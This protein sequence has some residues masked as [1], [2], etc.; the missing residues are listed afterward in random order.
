MG[1]RQNGIFA[2]F[3]TCKVLTV[4]WDFYEIL[5]IGAVNEWKVSKQSYIEEQSKTKMGF[6]TR[7]HQK[8]CWFGPKWDPILSGEFCTSTRIPILLKG[9]KAD[10]AP[11]KVHSNA[12]FGPCCSPSRAPGRVSIF[13]A[14]PSTSLEQ[15]SGQPFGLGSLPRLS[16]TFD[17]ST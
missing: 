14:E 8:T 16:R 9:H 5:E 10:R 17:T 13:F 7:I 11:P 1:I 15:R 6:R 2:S 4:K 3:K 12:F